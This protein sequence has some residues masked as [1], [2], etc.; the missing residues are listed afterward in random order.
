MENSMLFF[1]FT[2]LAAKLVILSYPPP[3][4]RKNLT[5]WRQNK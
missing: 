3:F 5:F 2:S 1:I 4:Y